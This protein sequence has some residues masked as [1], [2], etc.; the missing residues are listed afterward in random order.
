MEASTFYDIQ[1]ALTTIKESCYVPG[2]IKVPLLTKK[3]KF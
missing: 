3:G 2:L 1:M